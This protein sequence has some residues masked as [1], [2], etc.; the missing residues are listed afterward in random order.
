MATDATG[1]SLAEQVLTIL[2]IRHIPRGITRQV[3]ELQPIS[4]EIHAYLIQIQELPPLYVHDG[5]RNVSSTESSAEFI[6]GE[7]MVSS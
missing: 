1:Q 5:L 4:L 2:I 6:P 7:D 3:I